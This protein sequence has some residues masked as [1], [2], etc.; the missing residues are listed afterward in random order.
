MFRPSF[1]E[2]MNDSTIAQWTSDFIA[3]KLSQVGP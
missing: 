2:S 1:Y 3:G